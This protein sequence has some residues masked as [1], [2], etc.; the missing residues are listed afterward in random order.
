MKGKKRVREGSENAKHRHTKAS[1]AS[2]G[3]PGSRHLKHADTEAVTLFEVVTMG[4]SAMQAVVDDWIEFYVTDR[5]TA[6]LDLISFFIQCSGCK[7][8]VT[9]EMFHNRQNSDV[10][11]KMV[12]ELDEG[13]GLQ[14]KKFLA[15]PWILTVTW[16]IDMDSGEYPLTMSGPYWRRFRSEFSEFVSVLVSQCQYSVIFD[17]YLMDTLISLLTQLSNSSM[18]AFRHTCTLAALKL[19]SS[20]VGVALSLSVGVDNSQRLYEVEQTKSSERRASPRLERIHRNITEV[21]ITSVC[22]CVPVAL[23]F[24]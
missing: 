22:M 11:R 19:L 23:T 18:R 7:G 12:E 24:S 20:L 15:F 14:Y 1:R 10:T 21:K 16:P 8:V 9:A 3:Q 5:D 17:G 4:R 13:S 2:L 6:L